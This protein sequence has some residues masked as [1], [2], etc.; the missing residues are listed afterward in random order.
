MIDLQ[1]ISLVALAVML[2]VASIIL[3]YR[4]VRQPSKE[5]DKLDNYSAHKLISDFIENADSDNSL[6]SKF[7]KDEEIMKKMRVYLQNCSSTS[8][9]RVG[10][11]VIHLSKFMRDLPESKLNRSR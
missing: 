6:D 1:I 2:G 8:G 10:G 9:I 4:T 11:T 5:L 7:E 3:A